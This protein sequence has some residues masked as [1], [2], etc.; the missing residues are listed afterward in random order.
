MKRNETNQIKSIIEF[1]KQKSRSSHSGDLVMSNENDRLR[2]D[3]TVVGEC[4]NVVGSICKSDLT[5]RCLKMPPR[6]TRLT[7]TEGLG[8]ETDAHRFLWR[9]P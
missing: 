1:L 4:F 7:G 9:K 6:Q 2:E 5:K 3:T 8:S